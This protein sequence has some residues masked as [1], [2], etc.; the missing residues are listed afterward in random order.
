MPHAR[1]RSA[2]ARAGVRAVRAKRGDHPEHGE[3]HEHRLQSPQ[4]AR[5]LRRA[6]FFGH[7][8]ALPPSSAFAEARVRR[9][10]C[11]RRARRPA[12]AGG[13]RKSDRGVCAEDDAPRGFEGAADHA[14]AGGGRGEN[15]SRVVACAGP[16]GAAADQT[17]AA[18]A[19]RGADSHDGSR[20]SCAGGGFERCSKKGRAECAVAERRRPGQKCALASPRFTGG[21]ATATARRRHAARAPSRPRRSRAASR[22]ARAPAAS[23]ARGSGPACPGAA[24]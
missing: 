15:Q 18:Q 21:R 12:T 20:A 1:F 13:A 19:D 6:R 3:H 10:R 17:A 2:G 14:A 8:P 5:L 16:R 7:Q 24:N 23:A 4:L 11:A 22:R 9:S